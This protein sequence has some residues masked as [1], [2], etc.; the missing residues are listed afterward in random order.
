MERLVALGRSDPTV[1]PLAALQ[2]AVLRAAAAPFWAESV[3][4]LQRDRLDAG[5]PL[6]HGARLTVDGERVLSLLRELAAV[7]VRERVA[8]ADAL[9]DALGNARSATRLEP[10]ALL[11]A[12][13]TGDE[14]QMEALAGAAGV[15]AGLLATVAHLSALPLLYAIG[16]EAA[17]VVASVPWQEGH[18]PLCAAWPTLAE[19]RGLERKRWLRCGRCATA[20]NV[21]GQSCSFCGNHDHRTLGYLAAEATRESQQAVTCDRCHSY[22]KQVATVSP[23]AAEELAVRDLTTLELDVAALDSGF[24]RPAERAFP[25]SLTIEPAARKF[26][27]LPWGR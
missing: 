13:L 24:A 27:W 8:G 2:A 17:P 5:M 18:C 21:P 16:R 10:L 15:D 26:G 11:E 1:A 22:L 3:P 7:A 25:L 4:L 19:A 23:L 12:T 9:R 14:A 6:L 20:W